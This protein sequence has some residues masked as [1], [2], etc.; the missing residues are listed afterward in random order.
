MRLDQGDGRPVYHGAYAHSEG[1]MNTS[2][3]F[4]YDI[5]LD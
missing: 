5:D 4:R 1:P 2:T 3:K